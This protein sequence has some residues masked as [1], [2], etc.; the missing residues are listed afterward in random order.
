MKMK[1]LL[2]TLLVVFLVY[3]VLT[4]FIPTGYFSSGDYIKDAITPIGLF[5]IIRYPLITLTSSVFILIALVIL[6][7]A[8]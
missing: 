1:N 4:W 7:Q 6:F 3:V 2:K 8:H 5:D